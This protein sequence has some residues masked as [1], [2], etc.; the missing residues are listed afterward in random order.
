M[1][2]KIVYFLAGAGFVQGENT[3]TTAADNV[4]LV[5]SKGVASMSIT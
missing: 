5:W 2:D 1:A 4:L 3:I